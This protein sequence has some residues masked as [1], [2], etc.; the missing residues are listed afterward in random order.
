MPA[1]LA[2]DWTGLTG[3]PC[4]PRYRTHEDA[5]TKR[6]TGRSAQLGNIAAAKVRKEGR[7]EISV[8]GA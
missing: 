5:N 6:E 7:K 4:S 3:P 8:G 1:G 2:L